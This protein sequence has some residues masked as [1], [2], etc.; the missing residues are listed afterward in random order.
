MNRLNLTNSSGLR[1]NR[2]RPGQP[3]GISDIGFDVGEKRMFLVMT[4]NW[5]N[6]GT[7]EFERS[8]EFSVG[9]PAAQGMHFFLK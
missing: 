7:P 4:E 1:E 9:G 2:G 6:I 5:L 8:F 3:T